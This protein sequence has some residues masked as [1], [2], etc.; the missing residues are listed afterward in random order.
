M[1]V[2]VCVT[3][4]QYNIQG[5]LVQWWDNA[6]IAAFRQRAQCMIDQYSGFK[7]EQT[8]HYVSQGR[9]DDGQGDSDDDSDD[10]SSDHRALSHSDDSDDD[11]SHDRGRG[12][13]DDDDD[14]DDESNDVHVR[15]HSDD[16][17]GS[18]DDSSDDRMAILMT[19]MTLTTC[20]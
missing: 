6:T 10:D 13:S 5:N 1:C 3:G 17:D 16:G 11:S 15:G 19:M 2:C 7:Q 4:R 9:R 12:D 20:L 14:T 8:G 18:D